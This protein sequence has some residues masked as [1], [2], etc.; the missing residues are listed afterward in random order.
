[1]TRDRLQNLALIA[2]VAVLLFAVV[3]IYRTYQAA[4]PLNLK[5]HAIIDGSTT[6]NPPPADGGAAPP[7]MQ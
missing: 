4:M 5:G 2:L 1:M 6:A 3:S 7:S